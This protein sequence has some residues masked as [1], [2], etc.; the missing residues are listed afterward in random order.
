MQEGDLVAAAAEHTGWPVSEAVVGIIESQRREH[1]AL[2]PLA[3]DE[4]TLRQK[5]TGR[6]GLQPDS[7]VDSAQEVSVDA[8]LVSRHVQVGDDAAPNWNC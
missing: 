3:A 4:E 6:A 2:W 7:I 8:K 1:V 5:R